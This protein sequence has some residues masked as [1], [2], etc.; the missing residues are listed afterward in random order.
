MAGGKDGEFVIP[1]EKKQNLQ[2]KSLSPR[3]QEKLLCKQLVPVHT[4]YRIIVHM[5]SSLFVL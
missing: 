4:M 3:V 1:E 2:V 5:K